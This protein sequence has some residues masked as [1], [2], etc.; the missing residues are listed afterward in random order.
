MFAKMVPLTPQGTPLPSWERGE[1]KELSPHPKVGEGL[2]VRG[3]TKMGCSRF[4]QSKILASKIQNWYRLLPSGV[5]IEINRQL[6]SPRRH[7][8]NAGADSRAA[9]N[10]HL[11]GVTRAHEAAS[12]NRDTGTLGN[13]QQGFSN[14]CI[15]CNIIWQK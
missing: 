7:S 13:I 14:L 15:N 6:L 10:F 4:F 5:K 11:A 9:I 12:G 8:C 1:N 3:I 2:G